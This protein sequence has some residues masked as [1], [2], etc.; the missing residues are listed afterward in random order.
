MAEKDQPVFT[1]DVSGDPVVLKINGRASYLTSGPVGSL[2]SLLIKEGKRHFIVDFGGCSGMDSTF[3]GLLAG[4]ALRL[5]RKTSD[6]TMELWRLNA[7]NRELVN[8]LGLDRLLTIRTEPDP[9]HG[10]EGDFETLKSANVGTD[11]MLEAHQDLVKADE[12]NAEKFED[13]IQYLERE[14]NKNPK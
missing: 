6:G 7:R 2:F 13:V 10:V 4:A 11:S 8:D 5:Q 3:L 9:Q 12:S 14:R 1:V